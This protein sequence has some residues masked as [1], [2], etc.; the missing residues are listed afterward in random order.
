MKLAILC[1]Y[2]PKDA[3]GGGENYI[4]EIWKRAKNDY[5][6]SL[7]SGWKKD[8]NLLPEDT[9]KIDLRNKNPVYNYLKFFKQSGK[10]LKEIK[11]DLIQSTCYEFPSLGIPT[12]IT[13]CHLG[14]L[15]GKVDTNLKRRLQRD[16]TIKRFKKTNHLIAISKSTMN[17][18]IKLGIPQ[19]KISLAYT[20]INVENYKIKKTNNKK[21]TI[22]CPSRI[23]REKGQHIAIQAVK[24]LPKEVREN[25]KLQIVGFVNDE[26]YLKELKNL[27]KDLDVE[28][29]SNVPKIEDYIMNSDLLVFPTMMWEGFGIVAGEGLACEKPVISSDYPSIREVTGPYGLFVKPGDAKELSENILKVYKNEDLR[30]RISKGGRKWIVD[31]YS[32]DRVYKEHKKVY[33]RII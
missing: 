33:D 32:W 9:N 22:I 31:N 28:F 26:T 7:I 4:Y 19:S 14:H 23:S 3:I 5:D 25:I 18:L 24:L 29:L 16:I 10:Y 17:D 20:G 1:R 11:P 30:E 15:M 27:S 2:F 8:P 13:V 6:T 12:V 21:F